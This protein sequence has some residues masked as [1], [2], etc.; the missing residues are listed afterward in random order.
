MPSAEAGAGVQIASLPELLAAAGLEHIASAVGSDRLAELRRMTRLQLL[1]HLRQRSI[2]LTERQRLANALGQAE[3]EG[4]LREREGAP[5]AAPALAP[6]AADQAKKDDAIT[7]APGESLR[8]FAIS[9]VHSDHPANMQWLV[10]HMPE[11][12]EHTRDVLLCPG[13]I[14]DRV[15]VLSEALKTLRA[16]FDEV[17]FTAG[18]HDLWVRPRRARP[19]QRAGSFSPKPPPPPPPPHEQFVA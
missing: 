2:S 10:E 1:E 5:A 6:A 17:C 16:R 14:S 3:R 9:D 8:I 12:R 19:A 7:L 4:R 18:N 13:D 11:R 15:E